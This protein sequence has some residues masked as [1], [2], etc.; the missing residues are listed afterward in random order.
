M[1]ASSFEKFTDYFAIMPGGEV[2]SGNARLARSRSMSK[3]GIME[4]MNVYM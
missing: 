3:I 4:R 1:I 2:S